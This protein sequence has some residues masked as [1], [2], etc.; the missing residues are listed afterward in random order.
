MLDFTN[1]PL[2]FPGR[3]FGP[4]LLRFASCHSLPSTVF[5]MAQLERPVRLHT[6][7][8]GQPCA[9]LRYLYNGARIY[10][11]RRQTHGEIEYMHMH[12]PMLIAI[13]T[14]LRIMTSASFLSV[15]WLII[16]R[17]GRRV[18]RFF[19]SFQILNLRSFSG[20]RRFSFRIASRNPSARR[21]SP[22]GRRAS[23]LK[24]RRRSNMNRL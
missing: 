4:S 18:N 8:G 6:K 13:I 7:S 11:F 21:K 20:V 1:I 19:G 5:T 2:R 22:A 15:V 24:I 14:V 17:A 9:V 3:T 10:F 12:I 16:R 23:F